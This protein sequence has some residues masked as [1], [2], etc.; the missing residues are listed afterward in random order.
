MEEMA[1]RDELG[2]EI[3]KLKKFFQGT[4][5]QISFEFHVLVCGVN[6]KI[7]QISSRDFEFCKID[8]QSL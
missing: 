4:E 1:L 8:I 3:R 5:C 6:W 7:I 2:T